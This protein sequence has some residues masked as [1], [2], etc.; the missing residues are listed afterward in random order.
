M[1]ATFEDNLRAVLDRSTEAVD[2]PGLTAVAIR[3][4][5]R[6]RTRGRGAAAAALAAGLVASVFV[7]VE[8]GDDGRDRTPAP[9]TSSASPTST[10]SPTATSARQLVEGTQP[11][12][13]PREVDDLPAA[14]PGT[15]PFLPALVEPPVSS[16]P[17]AADPI[18]AAVLVV[19]A[20]GG[21]IAKLLSTGGEWRSVPLPGDYPFLRLSPDGTRLLVFKY[22]DG[23]GD[24]VTLHDL[25]SGA[26][27]Q[28]AY[29]S[30]Y[31][32][33]NSPTWDWVDEQTLV[34]DDARGGWRIDASTGASEELPYPG[35]GQWEVAADGSV[36]ESVPSSP[37]KLT[38]WS[39]GS[40]RV[41]S[42][43]ATGRLESFQADADTVVGTSYD[44]RP[45]SVLVADRQTL[46][47]QHVLPLVDHEGNYSGGG[48]GV[49]ALMD[50]GTVLLRVAVFGQADGFRVVRWE[51]ASGDLSLVTAVRAPIE[52]DVTFASGLV[53]R[54]EP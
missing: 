46:T 1:S 11:Q 27:R 47:P 13:D 52:T 51:P 39:G 48:L 54:S 15:A 29:P 6:R 42:E 20:R 30:D 44:E 9:G 18:D 12:W 34:L 25:P 40:A 41:V 32:P 22:A 26:S 17:L 14:E 4:A 5:S 10:T 19:R 2:T 33:W 50:D 8:V 28:L 49:L 31:R 45:F 43:A 35:R 37:A 3:E 21:R 7:A 23:P 38:D 36:V 16:T 24:E 53:R